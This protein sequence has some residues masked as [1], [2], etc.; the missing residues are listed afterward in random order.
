[1]DILARL[2][3]RHTIT[4]TPL[5]EM[6]LVAQGNLITAIQFADD[7]CRSDL[8][9]WS[10]P[11][12]PVLESAALQLEDYFAARIT[13]FQL[14]LALD[15]PARSNDFYA[16]VWNLLC[17][18]PYGKTASYTQIALALG[19]RHRAR[20]VGQAVKANPW[21]IVVPCH[22][23]IHSNGSLGNYNAGIGRKRALLNLEG[24]AFNEA[25]PLF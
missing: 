3:L 19:N 10:Y 17:R 12:D 16:Q 4:V 7:Y 9:Q 8:G 14:P 5:G 13:S 24:A 23:V 15:T 18:I 20:A 25:T 11:L 2:P 1:M 22:R 21:A 6:Y